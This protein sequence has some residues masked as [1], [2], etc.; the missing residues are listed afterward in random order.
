METVDLQI[1]PHDDEE[2]GP[3]SQLGLEKVGV[4]QSLCW[5]MDRTRTDDDKES[6]IMSSY[7]ACC[8]V[9]SRGD[10]FLGVARGEDLMS[11]KSGLDQRII[12]MEKKSEQ[13]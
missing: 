6:N 12:L 13:G 9:T 2:V 10:C 5:T 1:S 7:N 4:L 3:V 8:I 11:E